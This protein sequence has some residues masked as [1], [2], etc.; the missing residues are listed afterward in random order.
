MEST[1]AILLR[2]TKFSET[3]LI[4]TWLTRD[5]GKLKT[6]AR[7]ARG[8]KS[9]FAGA[10]DLFFETEISFVRSQRSEIHT[11]REVVLREPF[12]GLRKDYG[13]VELGA[14]FVE[15][16]ELTTEPEHPEPE[17]FGLIQRALRYLETAAPSRRALT[18]FESE[19]ARLLGLQAEG[20][21][22]TA[23]WSVGQ[24]LPEARQRLMEK[25]R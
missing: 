25:L 22:S 15:L 10:L 7:G 14:Y 8:R 16:L 6:M 12:E 3:S 23:L 4:V 5:Y 18:H 17:L 19:L 24:R 11:L 21:A 13:R 20:G 1:A 2:R 9:P